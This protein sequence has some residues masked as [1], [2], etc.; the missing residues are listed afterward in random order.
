MESIEEK[1]Y[2]VSLEFIKR[3]GYEVIQERFDFPGF[4]VDFIATDTNDDIVFFVIKIKDSS[5]PECNA[6][7]TNDERR[8]YVSMM[9]AFIE[10]HPDIV[11]NK[12][13]R[14]DY[15]GIYPRGN[16]ALLEHHINADEYIQ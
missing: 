2:K 4:P 6:P 8:S 16:R 13:T 11:V 5:N 12:K 7:L 1:A 14:L 10:T 15:I 3:R 9:L